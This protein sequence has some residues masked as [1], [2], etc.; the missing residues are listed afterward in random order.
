MDLEAACIV[1]NRGNEVF[2]IDTK[3]CMPEEQNSKL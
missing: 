3:Y 1:I 2:G